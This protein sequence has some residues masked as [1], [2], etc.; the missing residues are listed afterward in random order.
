MHIYYSVVYYFSLLAFIL[1]ILNYCIE[2][3]KTHKFL[4]YSF[5]SMLIKMRGMTRLLGLI[6]H[7]SYVGTTLSLFKRTAQSCLFICLCVCIF[8]IF[9][10]LHICMVL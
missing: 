8:L 9:T 4:A 5:C 10:T 6:Y 3:L 1:R 2:V 7:V